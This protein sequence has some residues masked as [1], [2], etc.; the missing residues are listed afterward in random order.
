MKNVISMSFGFFRWC[1]LPFGCT[2]IAI[3]HCNSR[4]CRSRRRCC[5]SC[6]C[7]TT[8]MHLLPPLLFLPL[9]THVES[10]HL[11]P[12]KIQKKKQRTSN[13]FFPAF[14]PLFS[15]GVAI[16]LTFC[17][18]L[19]QRQQ[20][21]WFLFLLFSRVC[22]RVCC[23]FRIFCC[24]NFDATEMHF[25]RCCCYAHIAFLSV[26]PT[27]FVCFWSCTFVNI[28]NTHWQNPPV[29]K[30]VIIFGLFGKRDFF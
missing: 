7:C 12:K 19:W 27:P 16:F 6:I 15:V 4:R 30:L 28:K 23:F 5:C 11:H 10:I 20:K 26:H 13:P 9:H 14:F 17:F 24:C 1:R 18:N 22:V 25:F 29:E 21:G 3:C 2:S 8:C